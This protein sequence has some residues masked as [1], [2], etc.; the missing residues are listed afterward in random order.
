M[1]NIF[2]LKICPSIKGEETVL[3]S[4]RVHWLLQSC[5]SGFEC[6]PRLVSLLMLTSLRGMQS[7]GPCSSMLPSL[8]ANP[9]I[10][11]LSR[12]VYFLG[13]SGTCASFRVVPEGV[14]DCE[15][16][17]RPDHTDVPVPETQRRS[18]LG[19][20]TQRD[21]VKVHWITAGSN[22]SHRALSDG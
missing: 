15:A 16:D 5:P 1:K 19:N 14:W 11:P 10:C 22:S 12:F 20:V 9:S 7:W 2:K 6:W 13:C 18:L 21:F 3:C 8:H 4:P 17:L